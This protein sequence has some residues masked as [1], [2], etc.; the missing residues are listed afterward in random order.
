[1]KPR[2]TQKK[3]ERIKN[4]AMHSLY[5]MNAKTA[6]CYAFSLTEDGEWDGGWDWSNSL[7]DTEAEYLL[8][9]NTGEVKKMGGVK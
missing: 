8:M 9:L 1:M 6:D 5:R 7:V 3:L 4:W 2:L